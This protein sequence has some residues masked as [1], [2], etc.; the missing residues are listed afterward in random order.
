MTRSVIPGQIWRYSN[1]RDRFDVKILGRSAAYQGDSYG[2]IIA[3]TGIYSVGVRS[4]WTIKTQI[5]EWSL[6]SDADD[7]YDE[8]AKNLGHR[9][10]GE[11]TT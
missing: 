10:A 5:D 7:I 4:N 3:T 1:G 2:V 9:D 11:Q 6:I 8:L